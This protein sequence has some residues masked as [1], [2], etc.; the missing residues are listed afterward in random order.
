MSDENGRARDDTDRPV[1]TSGELLA[2][3]LV[4][5]LGLVAT[6]YLAYRTL[7]ITFYMFVFMDHGSRAFAWR[8]VADVVLISAAFWLFTAIG[9]AGLRFWPHGRF[10]AWGLSAIVFQVAMAVFAYADPVRFLDLAIWFD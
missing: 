5:L 1:T 4:W 8:N 10:R 7:E 3:N 6:G 9:Y 2:A